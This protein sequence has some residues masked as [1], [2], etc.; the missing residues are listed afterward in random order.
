VAQMGDL[1]LEP[2]RHVVRERSLRPA[3]QVV[4]ITTAVLGRRSS[5][6]GAVVQAVDTALYELTEGHFYAKGG[7]EKKPF[8]KQQSNQS[9]EAQQ[10][11]AGMSPGEQK[12]YLLKK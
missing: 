8:K 11:I 9:Q 5:S 7:Q 1:L 4:R 6:M 2:I 12:S 3:A 10:P